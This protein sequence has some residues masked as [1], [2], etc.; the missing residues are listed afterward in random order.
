MKPKPIGG[1]DDSTYIA[2]IG[3]SVEDYQVSGKGSGQRVSNNGE[4]TLRGLHCRNLLEATFIGGID[5]N[6]FVGKFARN[7]I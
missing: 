4:D 3:N 1:A 5:K 6:I 7:R 2:R